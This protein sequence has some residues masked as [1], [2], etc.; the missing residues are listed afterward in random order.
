M[1]TWDIYW[2]TRLEP[3]GELLG[4]MTGGWLFF[5]LVGGFVAGIGVGLCAETMTSTIEEE[6]AL[7]KKGFK[8][9]VFPIVFGG[10]IMS[11][12]SAVG[13]TLIPTNKDLAIIFAGAWATNSAE[14]QR[15]PENV[16]GT[17]NKFMD[18]YRKD[19]KK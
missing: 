11:G 16:V 9:F 15:L 5:A 3:L 2:L 7:T 12:L 19:E 13:K 14:M 10:M 17:I 1:T 4:S 8:F 6:R 18:D